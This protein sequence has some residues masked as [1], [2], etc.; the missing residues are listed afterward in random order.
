MRMRGME[1]KASVGSGAH[2][3]ARTLALSCSTGSE[4][5]SL[6]QEFLVLV[7]KFILHTPAGNGLLWGKQV[8]KIPENCLSRVLREPPGKMPS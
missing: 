4:E 5:N 1:S 2:H 7:V 6:D 8:W 3:P